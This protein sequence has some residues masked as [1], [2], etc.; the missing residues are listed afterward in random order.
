MVDTGISPALGYMCTVPDRSAVTLLP[1]IQQHVLPGTTIASDEW[2][3][4]RNVPNITNVANH[5]T[6][7]HSVNF[8]DPTTGTH[9]QNIESYWSRVKTKLKRMKGSSYPLIWMSSCGEK[10]MEHQPLLHSSTSCGILPCLTSL[11]LAT[12]TLLSTAS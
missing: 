9:T 3:A 8:V 1:I 2:R 6:V 12:W 7:N 5:Q 11:D 10:D 4:Y